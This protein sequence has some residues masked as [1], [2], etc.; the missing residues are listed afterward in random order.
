MNRAPTPVRLILQMCA[1]EV[2][3][4]LDAVTFPAL[5][6]TFIDGRQDVL[7][8]PPIA[9]ASPSPPPSTGSPIPLFGAKNRS[10]ADG[11]QDG[12]SR[13][14]SWAQPARNPD[15]QFADSPERRSAAVRP[16]LSP[17]SDATGGDRDPDG[18]A[19]LVWGRPHRSHGVVVVS[20]GAA[21]MSRDY[22]RSFRPPRI[23]WQ[24]PRQ[25]FRLLFCLPVPLG[26]GPTGWAAEPLKQPPGCEQ[27]A[28]ALARNGPGRRTYAFSRTLVARNGL[29][30]GSPHPALLRDHGPGRHAGR[31]TTT[32]NV[33]V[34]ADR[35]NVLVSIPRQSRGL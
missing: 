25:Q 21:Q 28:T 13:P 4:M 10:R 30:G 12:R 34:R 11:A 17:V 33:G 22:V 9:E 16:V 27:G 26:Q 14:G 2:L 23:I 29:R 3:S 6:P 15:D 8:S 19:L 35:R 1:A 7:G 20:A 32:R 18:K 24:E 31:A 5:L